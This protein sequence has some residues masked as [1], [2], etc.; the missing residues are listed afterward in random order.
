M[1][2]FLQIK[3]QAVARGH[4]T[5]GGHWGMVIRKQNTSKHLSLGYCATRFSFGLPSNNLI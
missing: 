3:K 2:A 4:G 1:G 5:G